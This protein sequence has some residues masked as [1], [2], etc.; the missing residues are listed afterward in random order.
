MA[1]VIAL[2]VWVITVVQGLS[3][4]FLVA[5]ETPFRSAGVDL[6]VQRAGAPPPRLEGVVLPGT[7]G[8]IEPAE[9]A[10]V[11]GLPG[12]AQIEGALY[13]WVIEGSTLTTLL[14]VERWGESQME[15]GSILLTESA[16][17]QRETQGKATLRIGGQDLRLAGTL[18]DAAMPVSGID[19]VV[20]LADARSWLTQSGRGQ[21]GGTEAV[22]LLLVKALSGSPPALLEAIPPLLGDRRPREADGD[23]A[24]GAEQGYGGRQVTVRSAGLLRQQSGGLFGLM[25][26]FALAV[27]VV[28][29][30]TGTATLLKLFGTD[31]AGDRRQ[32]GVLKALGWT[33]GDLQ[34]RYAAR[35]TLLA[36]LGGLTGVGASALTLLLLSGL[37]IQFPAGTGGPLPPGVV[38][39]SEDLISVPLQPML[40]PSLAALSLI[41]TLALGILSALV[42]T[43]RLRKIK[44][45]GVLAHE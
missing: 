2:F 37:S 31:L 16:S 45:T 28:V 23:V 21:G 43:T 38:R 25:S 8:V 1:G 7:H 29:G 33:T 30:L 18:S 24:P 44:P 9:V 20:S 42:M 3:S 14:G 4:A 17:A 15:P 34:R 19:G 12:V 36:A 27:T 11:R 26:R 22:N 6:T 41:A 10:A 32:L 40:S 35:A 13:L 39:A 5:L